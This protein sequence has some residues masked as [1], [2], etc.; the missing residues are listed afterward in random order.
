LNLNY[1]IKM[2]I[3]EIII[4]G[5][6]SYCTKTLVNNLDRYFNAITGLN[7]SGKSNIL[8]AICFVL[9]ISSLSHVRAAN[10][11]ELVYKYGNSGISKASVSIIFDN[12]DKK[13]SPIGCEEYDQVTI[14]RSIA[15]GKSKYYLNGYTATQ[16]N[17][18]SLFHS[19]Q[20]NINNPHFLIMQGKVTQV[21]NMKPL[22]ILGLLEEAAGTSIYELKKE[23]ALKTIKK[24]E[25]KLEEINK[26]LA[27]EISPQLE[28]L[29]K[30]KQN[31]LTWKSRENEILRLTKTIAAYDYYQLEKTI[32]SRNDETTQLKNMDDGYRQEINRV[33]IDLDSLNQKISLIESKFTAQID[34]GL[35][36]LE[37]RHKETGNEFKNLN[38]GKANILKNIELNNKEITTLESKNQILQNAIDNI[39]KQKKD[40]T[41]TYDLLEKELETKSNFL[42]ELERNLENIN[43]GRDTQE[44]DLFNLNKLTTEAKNN[45]NKSKT[46]REQLNNQI[47]FIKD[48]IEKKKISMNEYKKST[49]DTKKQFKELE[50]QIAYIKEDMSALEGSYNN[51][52]LQENLMKALQAKEADL[53]KIEG[54]HND[55][56]ARFK[57]KIE[58]DF[59]DPEN[60]FDRSK[61]KGRV[62]RLFT[63]E[64]DRFSLA[65]EQVAGGK[66]YS[67]VVDNE[68]TS[69]LLLSRKCFNHGVVLIPNSKITSKRIPHD[70]LKRI[71]ELAGN[72][73][74]LA[75][76]LVKFDSQYEPTMQYVFGS[77]IVCATSEIAKRLAYDNSIAVRCVNLEGDVFDSNGTMSGG[78][79]P[80]QQDSLLAKVQEINHIQRDLN[81]VRQDIINIKNK[82]RGLNDDSN[83]Y[84]D[85]KVKLEDLL[86]QQKNMD[87]ESIKRRLKT[88]EAGVS[89]L[90]DD[91][92][93]SE[94]RIKEL[95]NLEAKYANEVKKLENEANEF[96][97]SGKNNKEI[98]LKKIKSMKD[99]IS[100][101]H[102]S[103]SQFK[104]NINTMDYDISNKSE[105]I[106]GNIER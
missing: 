64:S 50:K 3:K 33:V 96:K 9:G 36:E 74:R 76:D 29:M 70:K 102:K 34:K 31:Y 59:R 94:E 103:I 104:K 16:D 22:E 105:E 7:G 41:S 21:V 56:M 13:H 20:L 57:S 63:L 44:S 45:I 25:N 46:E 61:V 60:N 87:E 86:D 15:Q 75:I 51:P 66:L 8:D 38:H 73:A 27:E 23:S 98:Y 77:T 62:L 2:H 18:K 37:A 12:T 17:I 4:D 101:L 91:C 83:K 48:E 14:T 58:I 32:Q 84:N 47:K 80:R 49:G 100:E 35:R 10:L 30:D 28:K 79:N 78:S 82:L 24:K 53:T 19:V 67:I 106:K 71:Q 5:F 85:L 89:K 92:K 55:L 69:S 1:N 6:K 39:T 40:T 97:N 90:E 95:N 54:Y 42:K 26:I 99:T 65:L 68:N 88:Y 93:R 72:D 11:Q 43:S 81:N 52:Q